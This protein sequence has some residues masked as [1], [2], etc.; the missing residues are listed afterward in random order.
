MSDPKLPKQIAQWLRK[1]KLRTT[2]G[3]RFSREWAS[4]YFK[5]R[6]FHWRINCHNQFER[7]DT[8]AEMNRW[9]LAKIDSVPMPTSEK[10]FVAAVEYLVSKAK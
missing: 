1:A 10:E 4:Y 7:G 9:A 2:Y 6:G 5:G 3:S 8:Y